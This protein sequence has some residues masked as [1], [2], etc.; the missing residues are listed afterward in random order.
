MIECKGSNG[1]MS[2]TCG[3]KRLA[4]QNSVA[5]HDLVPDNGASQGG[6]DCFLIMRHTLLIEQKPVSLTAPQ[7]A[8]FSRMKG[9]F[10]KATI[11]IV[12]CPG[13]GECL[14]M[15]GCLTAISQDNNNNNN[16]NNN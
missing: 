8:K 14:V 4:R 1:R 12:S 2:A 16:N 10:R 3:S 7:R 9:K 6:D 11:I 13:S 15:N 5:V